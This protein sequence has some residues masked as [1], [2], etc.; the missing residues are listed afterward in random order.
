[1][2]GA[3]ESR[4]KVL[5]APAGARVIGTLGDPDKDWAQR[6]VCLSADGL[7]LSLDDGQEHEVIARAVRPSWPPVW[8]PPSPRWPGVPKP[9]RS[10]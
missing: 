3:P 8:V 6:L 7:S 10:A 2:N 1:M 4:T 9:V 5:M